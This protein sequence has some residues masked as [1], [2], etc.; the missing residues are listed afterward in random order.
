M[1]LLALAIFAGPAA[2]AP[3]VNAA[4]RTAQSVFP[5]VT[6]RCG[7]VNLEIGV[8]S[9]VNADASAETYFSSC[10]VRLAPTTLSSV[11]DEQLCSL[12]IHEFGHLAGLDDSPDPNSVMYPR[13]GINPTCVRT[14]SSAALEAENARQMRRETVKDTL[15]DL[16]DDLRAARK[17]RRHARGAKHARLNRKVKH[18]EKRIRRLKAE[19]KRLA[20]Q[21]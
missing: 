3:D 14:P 13:V 17:A 20:P 7:V 16:R 4:I 5:A 19:L 8:L 2:A 1:S 9:A 12:M 6:Q 21:S 18:L 11:S 15:T 10:R